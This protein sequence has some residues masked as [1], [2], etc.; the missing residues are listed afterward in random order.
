MNS[1]TPLNRFVRCGRL[2]AALSAGLVLIS[3]VP[4]QPVAGRV[5][6][7]YLLI[8]DT[9]S[10][11]KKRLPSTQYAVERLFLSM[12]NGQ[13]EPGDS[14]GVWAFDR[15]LRAGD[16][17]LQHWM[18]QNAAMIASDVTNF[19][20]RQSYA[21]STH[22][23]VVAPEV[24]GL[25]R[26]SE[27][28][29][30]LIFCDGGGE[31]EGT[32]YDDAIN[33]TF[34]QHQSELGKA[35]QTFIV[36][37][38]SQLGQFIGFTINS[39]AV[40]VNFP[41]FPPLP[42]PPQPLTPVKSNPAPVPPP[43]PAIK[44]TPLVIIGTNVSTTLIPLT[45]PKVVLTNPPPT[46]VESNPPPAV[47]SLVIP[48]NAAPPKIAETHTNTPAPPEDHAGLSRKGALAIGAALLVAAVVV[49]LFALFRTGKT[50]RGSL[51]TRSMRK[52]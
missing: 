24:T 51:I 4:A 46:R 6:S 21:R 5:D 30:V 18:P 16:F 29:T 9:S 52:K 47:K 42:V 39:S 28:L 45:P 1:Q 38:R 49:I 12:M 15:K 3:A 25:V 7:R 40:G 22:F 34:K 20:K 23:D 41:G 44:I 48:T 37:L 8:F 10:A 17:P 50:D 19:V 26:N 13:L 32:P 36:V 33:A 2:I 31:I 27:R 35:G 14:I 43:A 11:M